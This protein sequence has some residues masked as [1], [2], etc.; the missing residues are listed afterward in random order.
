MTERTIPREYVV[1]RSVL[2]DALTALR[3]HLDAMVLVGAQAVYFHTGD[4]DLATAPTTT[5]ADV[6]LAPDRLAD[7]PLL[8]EALRRAGFVRET[9]PGT[10]RGRG[11]VAI[12]LMVPEALSGPGNRGARL[13]VHGKWAARRARGLEPALI[14]NE[15][16]EIQSFEP[17]DDRRA[18]L[19]VAGPAA[20]LVA[21]V[22]K[23]EERRATPRRLKPKDGLDV[24]RLL[25]VVD[26]GE[27][28][29]RLQLLAA[30]EMAGEVTRSALA[31]L[32]EHGTES[33]G[34]IA[35]LAASA[36]T[37]TEDPDITIES[38]VL[39]VEELLQAC[40]ERR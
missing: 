18:H 20:L 4:A 8:E 37:G 26:M 24:L 27:V 31:S 5:D 7:E 35:A 25:R 22:V 11:A 33:D 34:P 13:P 23:I 32:R 30:D 17:G 15:A 16:H 12:D 39:L 36:V 19:R 10:W 40:D 1:A 28:A 38:T 6:A 14:D 9:D 2:L 21:K 3:A 29:R